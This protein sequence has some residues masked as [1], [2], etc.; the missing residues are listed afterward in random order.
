[1]QEDKRRFESESYYILD[2]VVQSLQ[3][4]GGSASAKPAFGYKTGADRDARVKPL[5]RDT[6]LRLIQ[7]L[8]DR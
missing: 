2:A 8:K 5:S 3:K 4:Q 1:M 7:T 6:I